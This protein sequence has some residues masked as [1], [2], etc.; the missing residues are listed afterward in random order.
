MLAKISSEE[1]QKNIQFAKRSIKNSFEPYNMETFEDKFP[2]I[3]KILNDLPTREVIIAGGYV[4]Y[5]FDVVG[6]YS[7]IDIFVF[8]NESNKQNIINYVKSMGFFIGENS[9]D[10]PESFMSVYYSSKLFDNE[11]VQIIL[12]DM[13]NTFDPLEK[14][15]LFIYFNF[16]THFCKKALLPF[17]GLKLDIRYGNNIGSDMFRTIKYAIRLIDFSELPKPLFVLGI[18][19]CILYHLNAL[20]I[21]K[22]ILHNTSEDSNIRT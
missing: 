21:K 17:F 19:N 8:I 14:I 12:I 20:P 4:S 13:Y 10:Y 5:L 9:Y 18:E 2:E 22:C 6:K 11:L 15:F 3:T 7:D 1:L 16:D